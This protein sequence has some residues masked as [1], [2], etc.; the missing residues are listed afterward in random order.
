MR[1]IVS[2]ML[3]LYLACISSLFAENP[4]IAEAYKGSNDEFSMIPRKFRQMTK[5]Q[6]K[7]LVSSLTPKKRR[8]AGE[9]REENIRGNY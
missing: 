6:R 2:F 4:N 1:S 5:E 9:V 7:K 3:V 8:S